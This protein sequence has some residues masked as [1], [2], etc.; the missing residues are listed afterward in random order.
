MPKTK[1]CAG[2]DCS[3]LVDEQTTYCRACRR[4]P[5]KRKM[6]RPPIEEEAEPRSRNRRPPTES[7]SPTSTLTAETDTN[8]ETS[9]PTKPPPP[10]AA[11]KPDDEAKPADLEA[12]NRA[13][14]SAEGLPDIIDALARMMWA[15]VYNGE[16]CSDEHLPDLDA[17]A[18]FLSQCPNEAKDEA[19]ERLAALHALHRLGEALANPIDLDGRGYCWQWVSNRRTI[20]AAFAHHDRE[21][22]LFTIRADALAEEVQAAWV[23]LPDK[24]RPQHPLAPI[25]QAWQTRPKPAE[26][27][28]PVR[29]GR[30]AHFG[31]VQPDHKERRLFEIQQPVPVNTCGQMLLDLP[32]LT[33]AAAG[34]SWQAD[35]FDRAGGKSM[36]QGRGAPWEMRLFIGAI[37]HL[38]ISQRDGEFHRL[39]FDTTEVIKWLHPDSW[40]NRARDWHLFPAALFRLNKELG[41]VAIDGL[42]YVQVLGAS[43]IPETPADPHVEFIVRIPNAAAQGARID[44]PTLCKYGQVSAI[45][46]RAYLSAVD[47]MHHSA[48]QGQPITQQIGEPLLGE[49]GKPQRGKGGKVFR[50]TTE[51]IDNPATRYVRGLTEEELTEMIG[52]NPTDRDH[53]RRTRQAFERLDDDGVI[54]LEKDGRVWRIFGPTP[55]SS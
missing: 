55:N 29:R 18:L 15:T 5:T 25:I 10:A 28:R 9:P 4:D 47:F 21:A 31:Q 46:Y 40:P 14:L 48:H 26:P 27:F 23:G 6:G 50:S 22:G 39:R 52:M 32:E 2:N 1:P 49:D 8:A 44:W 20:F 51:V 37:L 3:E 45:L 13:I 7:P 43:I 34:R 36:R 38:G 24:T 53:R 42:G 12:L 54:D 30:L 33:P 35:L 19:A 17:L 16:N 11:Q 41:F